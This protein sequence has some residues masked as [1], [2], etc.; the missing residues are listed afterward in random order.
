[1]GNRYG[2]M[3]EFYFLLLQNNPYEQTLALRH[4]RQQGVHDVEEEPIYGRLPWRLHGHEEVPSSSGEETLEPPTL[5]DA[6]M[7]LTGYPIADENM[8]F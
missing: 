1:M 2:E 5:R 7:S 3:G 4:G 6:V 8:L